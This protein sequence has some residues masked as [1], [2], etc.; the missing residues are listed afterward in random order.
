MKII[1]FGCNGYMGKVVTTIVDS[2]LD[3][4]IVA[5]VDINTKQKSEYPVFDKPPTE[6]YG[7]DVII[8][9]SIPQALE[10]LLAFGLENK[11]PLVLCST[12]YSQE[13]I[14]E[15]EKAS[16]TIPIFRSANMSIG[17]NLLIDLVK[18]AC[19]VLGEDFD[20]EIIERHHKRKVDAPSGTALMLADAAKDSLSYETEYI[21]ERESVRKPR[22]KNDIG[23]S[24]VRGGTI[25]GVHDV[26][27]A[28][29]HEVVEL[30]H[31]AESRDVFAIGAIRAAKF[32][33]GKSPCLYNMSDIIS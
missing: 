10:S 17:I 3:A 29:Q 22:N 28:G 12:G 19:A 5:G 23:I 1:L 7:A 25:V 2:D 16:K 33:V 13:Q 8:D 31:T 24:A 4:I 27:F 18:R 30:K 26:I 6:T 15:I 20:I 14:A 11:L 21:F 32:M 9:F